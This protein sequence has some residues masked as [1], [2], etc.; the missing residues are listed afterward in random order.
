MQSGAGSEEHPGGASRQVHGQPELRVARECRIAQVVD[1]MPG[2]AADV[3]ADNAVSPA[4]RRM[5]EVQDHA[6]AASEEASLDVEGCRRRA[7]DATRCLGELVIGAMGEVLVKDEADAGAAF[8]EVAHGSPALIDV[9]ASVVADN[10][11]PELLL[12]CSSRQVEQGWLG[13][14]LV[15]ADEQQGWTGA[16]MHEPSP[17]TGTAAHLAS[18]PQMLDPVCH[19]LRHGQGRAAQ[20]WIC[21][22]S[23]KMRQVQADA[24]QPAV[25]VQTEPIPPAVQLGSAAIQDLKRIGPVTE[26]VE[27]VCHAVQTVVE[28]QPGSASSRMRDPMQQPLLVLR[29]SARTGDVQRVEHPGCAVRDVQTASVELL[30]VAGK[31]PVVTLRAGTGQNGSG[32]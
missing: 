32:Q 17:G 29:V 2:Q 19:R 16:T 10:A 26:V 18:R 30:D 21:G 6:R 27:H 22:D 31:K 1:G 14:L 9:Q 23:G 5:A 7:P 15:E 3:I 28:A 8:G 4:A 12:Q 13:E 20:R 25:E 24:G 11:T